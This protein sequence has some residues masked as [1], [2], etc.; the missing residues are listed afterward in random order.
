VFGGSALTAGIDVPKD[1]PIADMDAANRTYVPAR[2]TIFLPALGWAETLTQAP[3]SAP[4]PLTTAAIPT[5]PEFLRA[6]EAMARLG[7]K[8]GT[9]GRAIIIHAPH[10]DDQGPDCREGSSSELIVDAHLLRPQ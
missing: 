1:R 9:E 2:N 6:F 3:S 4:M 8:M 10:R 7:T 5:P